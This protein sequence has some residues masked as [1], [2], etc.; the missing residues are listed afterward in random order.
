V[1]DRLDEV[2]RRAQDFGLLGPGPID[3]QRRHAEAFCRLAL[4]ALPQGGP[5]RRWLDLGSGGGLPGLVMAEILRPTAARG[6]LLDSRQRRTELLEEALATL[7]LA[8]RVDVLTARA[9]DAAQGADHRE[10]YDLVVARSF[11]PPPVTAE[12][13]TGFLRPGGRLVVSEPPDEDP[14]RWD[15]EILATL[16]LSPP[17][18]VRTQRVRGESG[19]AALATAAVLTKVGATPTT[20]P[21]KAG[22]PQKRPLW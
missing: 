13:A 11:A 16:A 18:I 15:A 14:A 20:F 4:Q 5:D 17:Q 19:G 22:I 1:P 12:C 2:L 8:E 7:D 9:E 21:R 10:G 6:T 3:G